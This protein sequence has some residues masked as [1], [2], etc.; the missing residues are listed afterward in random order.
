MVF[1]GINAQDKDQPVYIKLTE[2]DPGAIGASLITDGQDDR[3]FTQ[4][5]ISQPSI[6][7]MLKPH[8]G[9]V[10]VVVTR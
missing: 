5:N 6:N 7:L 3:S 9:F 10:A 4:F 1:A 2:L 8:G